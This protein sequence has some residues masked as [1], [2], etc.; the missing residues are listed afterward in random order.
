MRSKKRSKKVN[1]NK[2]TKSNNTNE[3]KTNNSNFKSITSQLIKWA[4]IDKT[5]R[6][7]FD[8]R[9]KTNMNSL[10]K[11]LNEL[12]IHVYVLLFNNALYKVTND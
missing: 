9:Y 5:K 7:K 4:K 10:K 3:D 11:I 6:F 8:E 12:K 2:F 1:N